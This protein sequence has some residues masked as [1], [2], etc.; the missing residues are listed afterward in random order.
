MAAQ[1]IFYACSMRPDFPLYY[2]KRDEGHQPGGHPNAPQIAKEKRHHTTLAR[3][4]NE[5]VAPN[6]PWGQAP[7]AWIAVRLDVC[8]ECTDSLYLISTCKIYAIRFDSLLVLNFL[9]KLAMD[10]HL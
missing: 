9:R 2:C 8:C 10:R 6:R 7:V 3:S 1:V 4:K 5:T